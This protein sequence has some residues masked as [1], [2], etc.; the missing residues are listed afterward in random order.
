M[1]I[2]VTNSINGSAIFDESRQYRYHL[3]RSRIATRHR[4]QKKL[5]FI[6]LN[7]SSADAEHDDP[8]LKACT[9]FAQGWGYSQL[10]IVNLF[11]YRTAQPAALTQI[12]DPIGP[13]NDHYLIHTATVAD[14]IIL[15]WGNW[16]LWLNRAQTVIN[17]LGPYR[18][19]LYYLK[20]NKTQQ[21]CHPLYIRRTTQPQP[22]H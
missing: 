22:W 4:S 17:L 10:H 13:E 16:G 11:A 3:T 12:S 8:T 19:K 14:R 18:H 21:P 5:I 1:S 20:R 6:M 15:A 7:P 2:I 9:Q